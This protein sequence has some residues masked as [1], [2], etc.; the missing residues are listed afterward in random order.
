MPR[1]TRAE[2]IYPETDRKYKELELVE[3]RR[4]FLAIA[5]SLA[6][7][8]AWQYF[9]APSVPPPASTGP[10]GEEP[11]VEK[12]TGAKPPV[13]EAAVDDDAPPEAEAPAE[14]IG[15]ERED[16]VVIETDRFRAELTNRGAQLVS[17]QLHQHE[18][19]NDEPVD[20]VRHRE[21]GPWPFGLMTEKGEPHPLNG[22]L[23]ATEESSGDGAGPSV[24]FRY[25]GPEGQAEKRFR[26]RSDGLI[27][28]EVRLPGRTGWGVLLGPGVRNPSLKELENRYEQRTAVYALG[29]D[30][31]RIAPTD[32]DGPV[33]IPGTNLR[34][35]GLD[36]SYFLTALL[37]DPTRGDVDEVTVVPLLAVPGVAEDDAVG[38]RSLPPE[39]ERTAEDKDL[40]RSLELLVVPENDQLVAQAYFGAKKYDLLRS[41]PGGLEETVDL[42][43]FRIIAAPL[44]VALHWIY[45]NVVRNYGWAI[46]LLT[47]VIKTLLLPL[48]IKSYVSMR[49]M[50]E[51]QPKMKAIQAKWKPKLKDKQGR[52]KAEMQRKMQEEMMALYKE[53]GVNPA[54]GCLP[55]LVQLPVLYGFYKLLLNA[56]ELRHAPWML[57]IQDLS[58][59]DPYFALPIAMAASQFLQQRMTPSSGDPMQRRIF[60]LMPLFLLIIFWQLPAGLVL[61]W[62]TNNVLTIV[63]QGFYLQWKKRGDAV[64]EASSKGKEK[65]KAAA[66]S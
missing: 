57:W 47:V 31:E 58:A 54:S 43:F 13:E 33:H 14:P 8:L 63:Q 62:L 46:V 48:T 60:Q 44:L 18:T 4:L 41:L 24:A 22:A 7:I 32:E 1:G 5:L 64:G 6:A 40:P 35:A 39:A 17:F 38:F 30:V 49:K 52:P 37:F 19:E 51:I 27:D 61:Y 2:W 12:T 53:H 21:E 34:W 56:V 20:L 36:D 45:E 15:A 16:R 10:A 11:V 50:Q 25:S 66:K 29:N 42:G 55:M 26:F 65:G 9:F 59:R 23:F 28:I 3:T